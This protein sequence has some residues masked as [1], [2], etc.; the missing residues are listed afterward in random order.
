MCRTWDWWTRWRSLA[1]LPEIWPQGSEGQDRRSG[2]TLLWLP[3]SRDCQCWTQGWEETAVTQLW[4]GLVWLWR[5]RGL[6]ARTCCW[7]MGHPDKLASM[8][9]ECCLSVVPFCLYFNLHWYSISSL[10]QLEC[11][12]RWYL[13]RLFCYNSCYNNLFLSISLSIWPTYVEYNSF[14]IVT[15]LGI[16]QAFV[17]V[18]KKS[19]QFA[20]VSFE[21]M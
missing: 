17:I 11:L 16:F 4:L 2:P 1:W 10:R 12:L 18:L 13:Y 3:V 21:K 15:Y 5:A 9:S 6:P 14:S 20:R 7:P 8:K 19:G